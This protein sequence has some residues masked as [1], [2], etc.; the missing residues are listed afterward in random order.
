M[1]RD[2]DNCFNC[3]HRV[4]NPEGWKLNSPLWLCAL[5]RPPASLLR[6]RLSDYCGP[7]MKGWK[8]ESSDAKR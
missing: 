6:A 8:K 7:R 4:K 3:A 1:A 5:G 2:K